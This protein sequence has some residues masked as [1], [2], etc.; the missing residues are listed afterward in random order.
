MAL[1]LQNTSCSNQPGAN[2]EIYCFLSQSG[3]KQKQSRLFP[4][5]PPVARFYCELWLV[6]CSI[7]VRRDWSVVITLQKPLEI[8]SNSEFFVVPYAAIAV[9]FSF[10]FYLYDN[11]QTLESHTINW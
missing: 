6:N 1:V 7:L 9:Y 8:T 2:Q 4:R 5:L 10:N 3:A 11:F